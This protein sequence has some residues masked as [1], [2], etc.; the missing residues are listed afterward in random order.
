MILYTFPNGMLK[1]ST[2]SPM[3]DKSSYKSFIFQYLSIFSPRIKVPGP[4]HSHQKKVA[5]NDQH[6]KGKYLG[7]APKAQD[8]TLL[9]FSSPKKRCNAAIKCVKLCIKHARN[10]VRA[11]GPRPRAWVTGISRYD[12]HFPRGM[13][14][15]YFSRDFR[16]ID[17]QVTGAMTLLRWIW[18]FSSHKYD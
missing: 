2:M 18:P 3:E 15:Q 14:Q 10:R 12:M 8:A 1:T 7:V 11:M 6:P 9:P 17:C 4:H 5:H 16:G 13:S